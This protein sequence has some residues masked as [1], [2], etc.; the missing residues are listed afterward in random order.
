MRQPSQRR[1]GVLHR[2]GKGVLGRQPVVERE[3]GR[4]RVVAQRAA[5]D[6]VGF[7][8]A[9]H[10]AAAMHEQNGGSRLAP[11]LGGSVFAHPHRPGWAWHGEIAD[12]ADVRRRDLRL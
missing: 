12:L 5:E 6:V 8:I 11:G 4:A 9:D 2:G 7:D 3:H 10:A 1:D